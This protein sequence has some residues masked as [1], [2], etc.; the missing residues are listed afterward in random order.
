VFLVCVVLL[1]A[2]CAGLERELSAE[3][4]QKLRDFVEGVRA[5][6]NNVGISIAIVK[7]RDYDVTSTF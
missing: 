1:P 3:K 7:V 6:R 5:C 4:A 2:A